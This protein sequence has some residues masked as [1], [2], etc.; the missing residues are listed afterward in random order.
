[1]SRKDASGR[2]MWSPAGCRAGVVRTEEGTHKG[3]PYGFE[4]SN[5]A[6]R[7]TSPEKARIKPAVRSI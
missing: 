6:A 4:A 2:P 5:R 7:S 3:C 1:M